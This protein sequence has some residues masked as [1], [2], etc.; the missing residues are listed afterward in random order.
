MIQ[1]TYYEVRFEEEGLRVQVPN[2]M[3]DQVPI[4]ISLRRVRFTKA[5]GTQDDFHPL[6]VIGNLKFGVPPRTKVINL[7]VIV[8]VD[9]TCADSSR[10][11]K[12][13]KRLALGY[14]DDELRRWVCFAD[15]PQYSLKVTQDG[16]HACGYARL[17]LREIGDPAISWGT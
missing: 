12:R 7:P 14:W 2:E 3:R 17:E 4:R 15:E 10:A 8:E 13:G 6:R 9:Y 16:V 5:M 11:N 1:E